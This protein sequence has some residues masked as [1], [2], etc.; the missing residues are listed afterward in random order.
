M[1]LACDE[2]TIRTYDSKERKNYARVLLAMSATEPM[3]YAT[4]FLG[5]SVKVRVKRVISYK[6]VT[7]LSGICLLGL[8]F[9]CAVCLLS[10]Q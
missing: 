4:G 10:N 1:E 7:L 5:G 6:Q 8:F 2:S 3:I 9:M